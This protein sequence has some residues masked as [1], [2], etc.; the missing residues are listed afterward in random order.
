MK[1]ILLTIVLLLGMV[2]P[3]QA[4]DIQAPEAP[5]AV[6]EMMPADS[7]SLG[8]GIWFI[9]KAAIKNLR[10]DLAQGLRICLSVTVLSIAAAVLRSFPGRSAALTDMVSSLATSGLLLS[11][12]HTLIG[13][14]DQTITQLSDYGKLLL[15]V[16][17]A[18]VA[19]QG[20][21]TSATAL[22]SGTAVFDAL[23]GALVSSVLVSMVYV[24]LTLSVADSILDGDVLKRMRDFVK[25]L[26][27]WCLKT[28]LYIFTGYMSITG[29]ISGVTDK[30][31]MK[32]AKLTISGVVPVVG[33]I[34]SDAS[35]AVLVSAGVVKS[36]AGVYGL[37][38]LIAIA[39]G[40]FLRIGVQ[41]LLLKLMSAM[42][43]VFAGKKLSELLQ[44]FS[45]AMGLLLGMTGAVSLLFV[46]SI[47]CFLKGVG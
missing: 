43:S 37:W 39:I 31:A 14:A 17:T 32:A 18:A 9:V 6:E 38:A 21:T 12:A 4:L 10:P 22:Y 44:S 23:L 13:A 41:Y 46:I 19:A 45:S 7:Q 5:E 33:G 8:E 36:A 3:V 47:V 40:P 30:A 42:C 27:T 29:V 34:M 15:P 26:V 24:Y 2:L 20:G 28:V 11:S 25:W 1:K 35:E 16:M